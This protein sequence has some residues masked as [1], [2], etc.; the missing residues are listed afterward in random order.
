MSNRE[1]VLDFIK[2][3]KS[4]G[5]SDE[6]LVA[7]LRER[8]WSSKELFAAFADYYAGLTGHTVPS[9]PDRSERA[10]EAFYYLL[11]FLTLGTWTI[12]LGSVFFLLIENRFPDPLE[13]L[14]TF[15]FDSIANNLAA[16]IVAFPIY[17]FVSWI[18]AKSVRENPERLESGVRKWLT[19]LA[20]LLVA[21]TLICDLGTFLAYFLRGGLTVRFVL[22]VVTI[23][24]IAS[25]VLLYYLGSL[26][27]GAG[28]VT[29]GA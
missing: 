22:K 3:A 14:R 18:I 6:F 25:G 1:S 12:S 8:G 27:R 26:R 13:P 24:I 20:M 2:A 16:L 29:H 5:A 11:A 9:G 4:E 21:A 23:L 7:L 15:D 17:V 10:K 28:E 19:Y